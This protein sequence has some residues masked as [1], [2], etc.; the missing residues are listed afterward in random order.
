MQDS[1]SNMQLTM[2]RLFE[3]HFRSKGNCQSV[4]WHSNNRRSAV[5]SK[6]CLATNDTL[7]FDNSV[8]LGVAAELTS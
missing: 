5:Q 3:F 1:L 4:M 8:K 7:E 6:H 2:I